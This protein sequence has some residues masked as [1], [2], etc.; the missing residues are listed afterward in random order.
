MMPLR[1]FFQARR[2]TVNGQMIVVTR[3]SSCWP[4]IKASRGIGLFDGDPELLAK[5]FL[6]LGSSEVHTSLHP[7]KRCREFPLTSALGGVATRGYSITPAPALESLV[8]VEDVGVLVGQL[9]MDKATLQ[10]H[11]GQPEKEKKAME[12][13]ANELSSQLAWAHLRAEEAE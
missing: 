1:S 8:G 12:A 6:S 7:H 13:W 4:S 9:S 3:G 5:V 10:A 2:G 11:I